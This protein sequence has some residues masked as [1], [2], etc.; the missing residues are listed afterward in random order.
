VIPHNPL[1]SYSKSH[2]LKPTKCTLFREKNLQLPG[3]IVKQLQ[4]ITKRS[5]YR[6]NTADIFV[7]ICSTVSSHTSLYNYL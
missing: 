4:V 6:Y 2:K 1:Y 5:V 7:D 3:A